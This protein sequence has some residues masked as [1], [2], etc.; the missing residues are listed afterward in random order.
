MGNI[1]QKWEMD[2]GEGLLGGF[3][4]KLRRPGVECTEDHR[5]LIHNNRKTVL[6]PQLQTAAVCDG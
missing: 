2:S 4:G 3:S 5:K 6:V 1:S